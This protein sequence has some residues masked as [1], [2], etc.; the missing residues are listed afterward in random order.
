[1]EDERQVVVIGSGPAGAAAARELVQNGITVTMLE[2]GS[3][4]PHGLLVRLGGKNLYRRVP[5]LQEEAGHSVSG[6]PRTQCFVKFAAGGLS[7]NWTGAVPRFAPEDF[8]EGERL[9]ER[10]RWPITYSDLVSYYD[11]IERSLEITAD[12][13]DVPQL[14]GG[15]ASYRNRIPNDWQDVERSAR[16]RNQGFTTYPLADGPPNLLVRRGTA[17]NSYTGIVRP[18]LNSPIFRLETGAHAL[19]LEWSPTKQAVDGVVYHSRHSGKLERLQASAV[20]IACGPLGSAKL[21]HN[22]VCSDFPN[23]LGNSRGLL[24]RFLHDHPREWWSFEM[25]RPRTFLSPSAYLTRLPYDSSAPLLA[26]S[27]TLGTASMQ[28][29]I[30]SRL[31]LKGTQVGVQ[32]LGT[33]IPSE[34]CVAKPSTTKKDEFGLPALD[35]SIRYSDAEVENVVRS[36]QHLMDLM[37][38]TGSRAA[39]GEIVPTLF[40]GTAAHY[41][42][43]ARMHATPEYGVVDAWNRVYDT[44]NVLV[45]DASCFTTACEKNPTLTVMAIAARA[46]TRLAHDLKHA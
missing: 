20:V 30:R 39:L 25:D 33:M 4:L 14:P 18:L 27:W 6:D 44:P 9:H 42:G 1:M 34:A 17:F 28:D 3:S 43:T 37:D 11:K 31:G 45:C 2:A 32:L 15:Y 29:R 41:G 40:P 23:G 5:P 12:P 36:R 38:D 13:R 10:F 8:T 46:A 21:L 16:K 19:H 22:S 35:V 24:G 7:N 26:T